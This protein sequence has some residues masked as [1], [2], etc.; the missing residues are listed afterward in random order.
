LIPKKIHYC[1]F[2]GKPLPKEV[3]KCIKSWKKYAPDYEIIEW[4]ES[5]FDVRQH[6]F[7]ATAYDAKAWAFVSDYARLKV[8][9]D[10]GGIY[11]DTDVE[12]LRKP[13]FLLNDEFYIGVQQAGRF[14]T[15]G[16]GFGAEKGN[17]IVGMML[18][19]YDNLIFSADN[20][21]NLAC[22]YL[23]NEVLTS[24]G[25]VY[26]EDI[27]RFKGVVVYPCKYFDPLA[28]GDTEDL[29]CDDTVSIHHYSATWCSKSERFKR[30]LFN[31]IGQRNI[32]RIKR[33][34]KR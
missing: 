4:N 34:F 14:C 26:S 30:K 9:F 29:L 32:N 1:W 5:N 15:T 7:M 13:D 16:L 6:Q 27:W 20:R 24:L 33:I 21:K 22:P 28:P 12:L 17:S 25:Y 8:I 2:G 19:K 18:A 3:K 10:N 23:N 11:F 31:L